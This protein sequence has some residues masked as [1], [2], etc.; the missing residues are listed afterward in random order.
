MGAKQSSF[1]HFVVIYPIFIHLE[2]IVLSSP[3]K[4]VSCI[5]FLLR[6]ADPNCD[7][8]YGNI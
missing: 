8:W 2:K 4:T 1:H 7:A 5:Q 6:T 3:E